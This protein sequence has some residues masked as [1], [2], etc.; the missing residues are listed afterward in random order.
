M[1]KQTLS[2]LIFTAFS[3]FT[4]AENQTFALWSKVSEKSTLELTETVRPHREGSLKSRRITDVVHPSVTFYPTKETGFRPTVLICPGGGY[5][6]LAM[7]HE[8]FEVADYYNSIGF[9]AAILKYRVPKQ[10]EAAL[11]DAH[12]AIKLLRYKADSLKIN[13]NQLGILGFSAGGHLAAKTSTT[14]NKVKYSPIDAADNMNARP[15]FTILIYPA[16]MLENDKLSSEFNITINTPPAL[17]IHANDDRHSATG[18]MLYSIALKKAKVESEVHVFSKGGH[19][20]G[21]RV[22]T[23]PIGQW[24]DLSKQW[25]ESVILNDD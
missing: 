4:H 21:I 20:F 12:R 11:D 24:P 14:Y 3:A 8:G 23:H 25:L 2:L 9:H 7:G 16:Y 1:I 15:D 19:G 10:R 13:P 18:S 22:K 5:S 17:L 6:G